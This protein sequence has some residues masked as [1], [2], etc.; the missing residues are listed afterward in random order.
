MNTTLKVMTDG[1]KAQFQRPAEMYNGTEKINGVLCHR[2]DRYLLTRLLL[3][4]T[5]LMT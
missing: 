3:Y 4:Y 1:L 2:W 5:L